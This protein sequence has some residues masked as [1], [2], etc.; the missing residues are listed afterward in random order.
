[1]DKQ[2]FKTVK[3]LAE[4][5]NVSVQTI[6]NYLNQI[7]KRKYISKLKNVTYINTSGVEIIKDL[8]I[9]NNPEYDLLDAETLSK[10]LKADYIELLKEQIR[11]KDEQIKIKDDQINNLTETIKAQQESITTQLKTERERGYTQA[12]ETELKA[13][14][15]QTKTPQGNVFSRIIVRIKGNNN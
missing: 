6:Y 4:E 3:Q 5:L 14:K 10:G 11:T 7:D 2:G 9:K 1:M 13:L 15:S 8:Y 12:L